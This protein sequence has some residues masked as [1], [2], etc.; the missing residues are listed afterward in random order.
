MSTKHRTAIKNLPDR[1][2]R[3]A[4]WAAKLAEAPSRAET[5]AALG[6]CCD[7]CPLGAVVAGGRW[8]VIALP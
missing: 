3:T 8:A 2:L 4:I 1:D 6:F 7:S 5:H